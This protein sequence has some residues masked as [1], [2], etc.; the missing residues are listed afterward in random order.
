MSEVKAWYDKMW[1]SIGCKLS[2]GL[3]SY[4]IYKKLFNYCANSC[5]DSKFLDIGCGDGKLCTFMGYDVTGIDI[6]EVVIEK[7]KQICSKGKFIATDLESFVHDANFDFISAIGSIEHTPNIPNALNKMISLGHEKTKFIMV[8]PNKDFIYWKLKG[9]PGTEQQEIGETLHTFK[10][11]KQLV[12]D[13]G[14][15]I[16]KVLSDGGRGGIMKLLMPLIPLKFA[17]QFIFV[18]SKK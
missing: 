10:E 13:A 2:R 15:K 1:S 11:W 8:V 3:E 6:S 5:A 4:K 16:D 18:M 9:I 7:A 17:Y 12:S 14:F